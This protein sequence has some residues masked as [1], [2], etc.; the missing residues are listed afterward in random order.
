M[1]TNTPRAC[2]IHSLILKLD[3]TGRDVYIFVVKNE[4]SLY[5][6]TVYVYT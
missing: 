4:K 1:L 5:M 2:F 3:K 6:S